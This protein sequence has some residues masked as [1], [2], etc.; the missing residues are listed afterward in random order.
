V[1][2]EWLGPERPHCAHCFASEFVSFTPGFSPVPSHFTFF[3]NRLNGFHRCLSSITGLKPGVNESA[4]EVL[5]S[6]SAEDAGVRVVR[7]SDA[8]YEHDD[9]VIRT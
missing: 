8:D 9:A 7:L 4:L 3:R 1:S 6:D 2:L 5:T